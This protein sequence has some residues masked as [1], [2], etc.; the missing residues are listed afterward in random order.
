M[1]VCPSCH[2]SYDA[3]VRICPVDG[4]P[5][6]TEP[7][8]DANIGQLLE[9]KYRIEAFIS[10]GGMGSV[11]RATHV[12]LDKTVA[13]KLIR[14]ELV[15]TADA[16]ARFQR[17]ARAAS[18]L[19]HPNIAAVFD[20][21]QTADGTLY[22]A[23]EYVEGPSLK[24]VIR[25][26]GPMD[27]AKIVAILGPVASALARAH[28][29]HIIHRD[30]KPHNIMLAVDKDGRQ[31]PKLL[32]FGIAKTVD[33]PDGGLTMTGYALGTPQYMSPEQAMGTAV[34]GRSDLYS[35][36]VVLYEMLIGDVPFAD[37]SVAGVLLKQMTAAPDAPSRRR[38]DVA[39]SP[40]LEAIALRCLNKEPD[41]RFQSAEAFI[42]ALNQ[43]SDAATVVVPTS[44]TP[45]VAV[46]P[47]TDANNETPGAAHSGP[48]RSPSRD[49]PATTSANKVA[50]AGRPGVASAAQPPATS[51]LAS[52]A[53]PTVLPPAAVRAGQTAG[54]LRQPQAVAG[55]PAAPGE[56]ALHVVKPGTQPTVVMPAADLA[57]SSSRPRTGP[58]PVF[59]IA[60]A[61]IMLAV[62]GS[63]AWVMRT[64]LPPLAQENQPAQAPTATPAMAQPAA[65]V[66][67]APQPGDSPI[68][69]QSRE[70]S[71]TPPA[72]TTPLPDS[73]A[74]APV[75]VSPVA[76][77]PPGKPAGR[78]ASAG[79]PSSLAPKTTAG[80]SVTAAASSAAQPPSRTNETSG[81]ASDRAAIPEPPATT[82]ALR[83]RS[84]GQAVPAP[85][86][87]NPTVFVQCNGPVEICS[88]VRSAMADALRKDHMPMAASAGR[89]DVTLAIEVELIEQRVQESFGTTFA[90]RTFA[91]DVAG[92]SHGL[93]ISMP[94]AR[95]FS[96]DAQFGRERA[97]ENARLI[98]ADAVEK[99]REFW[100][101]RP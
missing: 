70:P 40:A 24:E 20:F 17:E 56:P 65:P 2:T 46:V 63:G 78:A 80:A 74:A 79:S 15:T 36:G 69:S 51:E 84:D 16:A 6:L 60:T 77:P 44:R 34:D 1:P 71:T 81:S 5:L 48:N 86:A 97:N 30:L 45:A 82:P 21:G 22:I 58:G 42:A 52:A 47:G 57:G 68:R 43:D 64:W 9:G 28:R 14:R 98:A 50:A 37:T 18:N 94:P 61:I 55:M 19:A 99:I 41:Q 38:P 91:V 29:H 3:A 83:E 8:A 93:L 72:P 101:N 27:P 53:P 23:M 89:A 95:T 49:T 92:E 4:T 31:T 26:D 35:L 62:V 33:D 13:I 73:A 85:R 90:P 7:A 76:T 67:T 39:I 75:A 87:E 12:M 66:E 11:Y 59:W 100:K 54:T 32:D 96:F 88:P 10:A 25:D